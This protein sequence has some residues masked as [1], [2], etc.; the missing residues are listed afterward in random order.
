MLFGCE[1]PDYLIG[2]NLCLISDQY[3]NF[4]QGVKDLP[5]E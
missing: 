1:Q 2:K 3:L 5:V 4:K